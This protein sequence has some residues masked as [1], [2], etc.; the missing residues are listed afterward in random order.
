M[1]HGLRLLVAWLYYVKTISDLLDDEASKT[2]SYE[3]DW[4]IFI[5]V[6]VD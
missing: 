1:N 5:S 3:Y 2:M 4:A 6:S